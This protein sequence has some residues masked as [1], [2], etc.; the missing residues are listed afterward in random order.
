MRF[1]CSGFLSVYFF[2][3][4]IYI[5]VISVN[6]LFLC[7]GSEGLGWGGGVWGDI[8]LF[9]V[10]ISSVSLLFLLIDLYCFVRIFYS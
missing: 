8:R 1:V 6:P 10:F 2:I 9:W 4:F 3:L 7:I 5:D